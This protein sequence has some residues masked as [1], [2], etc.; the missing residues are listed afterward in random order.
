MGRE[1]GENKFF[2][3]FLSVFSE[4]AFSFP[5]GIEGSIQQ[6]GGLYILPKYAKATP[7]KKQT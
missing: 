4:M 3:N 7:G 6:T 1:L 5:F 2:K